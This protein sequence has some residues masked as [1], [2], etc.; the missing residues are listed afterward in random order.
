MVCTEE[1]VRKAEGGIGGVGY[2][3]MIVTGELVQDLGTKKFIPV[4]RQG[5]NENNLVPNFLRTRLYI[6]FRSDDAFVDG[7]AQL[8]DSII[9]GG[10]V[11]KPPLGNPP[12]A[13][14]GAIG[15]IPDLY[16][17]SLTPDADATSANEVY[18]LAGRLIA[19][20]DIVGWR[21]LAQR[22]KRT[23]KPALT[24]LRQEQ[25]FALPQGD[26]PLIDVADKAVDLVAP[27]IAMALAGVESAQARFNDQRA[28][29]DGL[30]HL[31]D[32]SR[33]GRV[34]II[35]LPAML[36]FVYQA[37][38]GAVCVLSDQPAMAVEFATM[39][40]RH[41]S[42]E[43]HSPLWKRSDLIGWPKSLGGNCFVAWKYL[44]DSYDK[45]TWLHD[46][47]GDVE[48][49]ETSL[50][51]YYILLNFMEYVE[52]LKNGNLAAAIKNGTKLR[53]EVP[54]IFGEQP[55]DF[56]DKALKQVARHPGV[57]DLIIKKFAVSK[58]QVVVEW[59]SW[60]E[61][62]NMWN[63]QSFSAPGSMI[64]DLLVYLGWR[65]AT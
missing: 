63:P 26:E 45:W 27:S 25:E 36:G 64:V 23:F 34:I 13:E 8:I 16:G 32:W 15:Q 4:I 58:N 14:R 42:T 37:L 55:K 62:C 29:F 7:L 38:H 61:V 41:N 59:D 22:L 3:K 40:V 30:Y 50:I 2:E 17:E 43:K 18:N 19:N 49:F 31:T 6:D 33:G 57:F 5:S 51:S 47:F 54:M 48:T 12:S 11:I 39:N 53:L 9:S 21:K 52:F 10:K 60:I 24:A 28:L 1:Y 35:E 46:I 56:V 65:R 20:E 44:I